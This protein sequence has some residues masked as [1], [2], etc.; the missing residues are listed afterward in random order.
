MRS[1]LSVRGKVWLVARSRIILAY[2]VGNLLGVFG[3]VP[4]GIGLN[5]LHDRLHGVLAG[6]G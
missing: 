4:D 2:G 5:H 3:C 6:I 1:I